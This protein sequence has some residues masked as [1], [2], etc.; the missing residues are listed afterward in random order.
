MEPN[1]IGFMYRHLMHQCYLVFKM[2]NVT[3]YDVLYYGYDKIKTATVQHVLA[4]NGDYNTA[5]RFY[6]NTRLSHS[7]CCELSRGT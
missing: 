5:N 2:Y 4:Q 6:V 3:M 7:N 1:A